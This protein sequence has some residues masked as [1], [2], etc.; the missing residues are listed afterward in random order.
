MK[1][2]VPALLVCMAV[3]T[4]T[5]QPAKQEYTL[6]DEAVKKLPAYDT[7]SMGAIANIV[8]KNFTGK[9]LK[10]RA[11]YAWICNN[12]AYDCKA[13][14]S[15]DASKSSGA[16]VLKYRKAVAA[17]YANLFQDM[18]SSAGIRCL[19]VD[20]YIKK[21]TDDIGEKKPELN[22]TWAVVQLGKS[23]EEWYYVDPCLG[24]G[25]TDKKGNTFIK[26]YDDAYF[27]ANKKIFNSQHFPDNEAWKLGDAPKNQKSFYDG[28]I[29]KGGAYTFGITGFT[30][31]DGVVKAK[32]GK[33]ALFSF[34]ASNGAAINKIILRLENNNK[35]VDKAI[36][37]TYA[38]GRVSFDYKFN[39][40]NEFPATIVVNDKEALTYFMKVE[41]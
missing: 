34:A 25:Y 28:P 19:T 36:N 33:P 41:E 23:P 2:I 26:S 35:F 40:E 9:E 21:T 30:P 39:D 37:F 3:F 1:K 13:G 27:F 12:I 5:A 10:A 8:T 22:H 29:V 14:K 4:A 20:G 15:N 18:C 16:D 32:T 38:N 7:L 24:A 6:V 17:G 11:I 31:A